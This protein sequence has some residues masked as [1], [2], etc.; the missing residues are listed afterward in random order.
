MRRLTRSLYALGSSPDP[1]VPV[2][3]QCGFAGGGVHS[4]QPFQ[5][6][7]PGRHHLAVHYPG[8]GARSAEP[9]A[10]SV[11]EIAEE[12][13][14][15]FVEL[16]GGGA[17][18]PNPLLLGHSMGAYVALELASL[19]EERGIQCGALIV[20]SSVPPARGAAESGGLQTLAGHVVADLD[21]ETLT[22]VLLAE[23]GLPADI[24]AE[25]EL[26]DLVLP[27]L[28]HDFALASA[29]STTGDAA[30]VGCPVAA[31]AG[32]D[33]PS[34]TPEEMAGWRSSTRAGTEVRSFPGGHF[35]FRSC[36]PG[37]ERTIAD[38]LS[39]TAG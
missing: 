28:R 20:S 23:G 29:Y 7:L 31:F 17:V 9:F 32:A 27:V 4:L 33:D 26:L 36:P 19:L 1:E 5:Q 39:R 24:L 16:L 21:D 30:V 15:A 38:V 2:V 11:Q 37:V 34:A 25:P 18:A 6:L 8:R 3:L 22:Q 12:A 10:A 13:A 35:W 14:G